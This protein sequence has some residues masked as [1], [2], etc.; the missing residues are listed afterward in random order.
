M[1]DLRKGQDLPR[2]SLCS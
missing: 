1:L 2:W